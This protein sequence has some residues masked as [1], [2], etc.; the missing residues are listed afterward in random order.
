[1]NKNDIIKVLKDKRFQWAVTGIVFL[2]ILFM[3]S[4]IRLSN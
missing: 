3:S 1:M 2:I 4:S